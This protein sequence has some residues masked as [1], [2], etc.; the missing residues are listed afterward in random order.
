MGT[1]IINIKTKKP[2]SVKIYLKEV[3]S[4][5]SKNEYFS[6]EK[7]SVEVLEE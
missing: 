1:I 5:I 3:L 4:T 2:E 7:F 6:I